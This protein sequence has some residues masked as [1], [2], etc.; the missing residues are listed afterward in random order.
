MQFVR[1]NES[2]NAVQWFPGSD[3]SVVE[4]H[5]VGEV[6][7]L[8]H[9]P[10]ESIKDK[11]MMGRQQMIRSGDYIVT[12]EW[13]NRSIRQKDEFEAEYEPHFTEQNVILDVLL[14]LTRISIFSGFVPPTPPPAVP[15]I[16][17]PPH[18][19]LDDDM[20][21]FS[22]VKSVAPRLNSWDLAD[23]GRSRRQLG[24]FSPE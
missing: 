10:R 17:V 6:F 11:M 7:G 18:W 21:R 3:A 16:K 5:F 4:L 14:S 23:N 24:C 13:G 8:L 9:A 15:T 22:P 20:V 2:I 12:D 1:K 19:Y